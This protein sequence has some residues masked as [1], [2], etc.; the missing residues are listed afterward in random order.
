MIEEIEE[1]SPLSALQ[2]A[3]AE[4]ARR[5]ERIAELEAELALLRPIARPALFFQQSEIAAAL[6]ALPADVRDR[7]LQEE[8]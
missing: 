4:I 3:D 5:D 7:L 8:T 2:M 6:N 1:L